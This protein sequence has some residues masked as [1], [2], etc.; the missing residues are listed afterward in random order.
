[1]PATKDDITISFTFDNFGIIG[2]IGDTV[3]IHD[4]HHSIQS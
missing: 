4:H 2:V 3:Y 1:M